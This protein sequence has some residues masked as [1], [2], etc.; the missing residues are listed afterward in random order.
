[1]THHI[2]VVKTRRNC[3]IAKGKKYTTDD[4][5]SYDNV[6]KLIQLDEGLRVLRTLRSSLTYFAKMQERLGMIRQ[7]GNPTWFFSLSA[8]ESRWIFLLKTLNRLV[9]NKNYDDDK[10]DNVMATK[11]RPYSEGP[12]Y[13]CYKLGTH[14]QWTAGYQ[15]YIWVRPSWFG[16]I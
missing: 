2:Y 3:K 7:L 9:D 8:A 12:C 15:N 4:P 5:K 14:R 10:I 11:V 1:M 16:S 6:N 13:M